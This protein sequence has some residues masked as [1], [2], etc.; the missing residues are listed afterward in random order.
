MT[1]PMPA[2]GRR[3]RGEVPMFLQQLMADAGGRALTTAEVRHRARQ[4]GF[5]DHSVLGVYRALVSM[6]RT[7]QVKRVDSRGRN[8]YWAS[9]DAP[10]ADRVRR[11]L[12]TAEGRTA[13]TRGSDT[14]TEPTTPPERAEGSARA[15]D[16]G[17][18]T[19]STAPE[20]G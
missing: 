15:E 20:T 11:R 13:V 14:A 7:G 16:I 8:V 17:P 3:G 12:T 18:R 4:A 10:E 1:G 19:R 9:A 6:E 2:D 5:C